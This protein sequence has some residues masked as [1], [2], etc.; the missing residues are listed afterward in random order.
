[1]ELLLKKINMD[2]QLKILVRKLEINSGEICP[3][4]IDDILIWIDE[5][6]I[7]DNEKWHIKQML[8]DAFNAGIDAGVGITYKQHAECEFNEWYEEY[9]TK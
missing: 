6:K 7:V 1:M 8:G 3:M 5:N 9:M 4:D 2:T